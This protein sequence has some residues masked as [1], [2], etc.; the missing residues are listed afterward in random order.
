MPDES[1]NL[2]RSLHGW[3]QTLDMKQLRALHRIRIQMLDQWRKPAP[4]G[5][6]PL[7]ELAQKS[8]L[9][10]GHLARRCRERWVAQEKADLFIHKGRVTW[11]VTRELALSLIQQAQTPPKTIPADSCKKSLQ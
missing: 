3:I 1:D 10:A 6:M 9:D 11:H 5:W 2:R 4:E 8:G 7:H